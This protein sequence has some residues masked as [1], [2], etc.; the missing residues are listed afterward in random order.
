[1]DLSLVVTQLRQYCPILKT[2]GGAADFDLGVETV[3]NPERLPAAYVIPLEDSAEDN[4]MQN[5]LLQQVRERCGIVVEVD[6][7]IDRRGQTSSFQIETLKYA[8]FK[9][10]LNWRIDAVRAQKGIQY[11]GGRIL[12][13][14]RARLFWQFDFELLTTI[15]DEDGWQ[16]PSV[17]LREI[18]VDVIVNPPPPPEPPPPEPVEVNITVNPG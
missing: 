9:S 8:I 14:D 13:M 5:G 18:D 6:N 15:I 16:E 2:V 11:A 12:T 10:I 4:E 7:A 1:M 3:V 17:D